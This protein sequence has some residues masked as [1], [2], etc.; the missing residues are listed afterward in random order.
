MHALALAFQEAFDMTGK[1][2]VVF[3]YRAWGAVAF[4]RI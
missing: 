4:S 1:A 3:E 2:I